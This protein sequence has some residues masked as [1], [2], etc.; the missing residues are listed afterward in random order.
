MKSQKMSR[1][2]QR[3]ENRD[4][5]LDMEIEERR[6][7]PEDTTPEVRIDTTPEARIDTSS[8][9]KKADTK[10]KTSRANAVPEKGGSEQGDQKAT[11]REASEEIN[12]DTLAVVDYYEQRSKRQILG[13]IKSP[14][15]SSDE[16][17]PGS[18]HTKRG[19]PTHNRKE[20]PIVRLRSLGRDSQGEVLPP[21]AGPGDVDDQ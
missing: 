19:L 5:D 20:D 14:A 10:L 21:I 17:V 8:S 1:L 12:I 18:K 16:A 15:R 9:G 3:L 13:E 11:A 7:L 4:F 6:S 2:R